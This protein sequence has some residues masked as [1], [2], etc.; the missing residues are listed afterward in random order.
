MKSNKI[1][2]DLLGR[3]QSFVENSAPYQPFGKPNTAVPSS[4]GINPSIT[5][6]SGAQTIGNELL[7]NGILNPINDMGRL[8]ASKLTAK[9]PTSKY[10]AQPNDLPQY[11]SLKSG[12]TKLGY[13]IGSKFNTGAKLALGVNDSP[14][15]M[16]GNLLSA[17]SPALSAAL[18][19]KSPSAKVAEEATVKIAPELKAVVAKMKQGGMKGLTEQEKNVLM[20]TDLNSLAA[21]NPGAKLGDLQRVSQIQSGKPLLATYDDAVNKG[22]AQLA[23]GI[24]KQIMK[25]PNYVQYH[26]TF[27]GRTGIPDTTEPLFSPTPQQVQVIPQNMQ[28]LKVIR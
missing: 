20:N 25:D 22:D 14:L 24:A 6:V 28:N 16:V 2:D 26:S 3:A 23:Q 7:G 1:L 10:T 19:G 13:Q 4:I 9:D 11:N 8:I 15:A 21:K 17:G 5:N 27:S 18:L 12:A